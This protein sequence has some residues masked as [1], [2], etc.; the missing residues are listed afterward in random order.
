[1][2]SDRTDQVLVACGG[3]AGVAE[4]IRVGDSQAFTSHPSHLPVASHLSHIHHSAI[5]LRWLRS[6]QHA[7]IWL[8]DKLLSIKTSVAMSVSLLPPRLTARRPVRP[9]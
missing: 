7:C 5:L 3:L 9:G 1:M 2:P 4:H 8:D 6:L